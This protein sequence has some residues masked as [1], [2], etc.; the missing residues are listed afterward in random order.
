[1]AITDKH[2]TKQLKS[3]FLRRFQSLAGSGAPAIHESSAT[4]I[5]YLLLLFVT[6]IWHLFTMLTIII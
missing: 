4:F 2:L 1:M 3:D 6:N 5:R